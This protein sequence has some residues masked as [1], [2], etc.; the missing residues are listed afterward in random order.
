MYKRALEIAAREPK[1]KSNAAGLIVISVAA[2]VLLAG[3][4]SSV[5]RAV[6]IAA[7]LLVHELGHYA[8]MRAFGYTD[9]KIFLIPFFGAATSGRKVGAPAWQEAIVLLMGPMPGLLAGTALVLAGATGTARE[10]AGIAV[11]VNAANLL[12][13]EPLDG[14]RVMT[15]TVFARHPALETLTAFAGATALIYFGWQLRAWVLVGVGAFMLFLLLARA[16]VASAA[17]HL[18]RKWPD[19]PVWLAESPLDYQDDLSAQA[20]SIHRNIASRPESHALW[21]RQIHERVVR[22]PPTGGTTAA[23]L[24]AYVACI[25]LAALAIAVTR[26]G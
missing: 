16:K 26:Q 10:L 6:L 7:V 24:F 12:P 11:F 1:Q 19:V 14:G 5:M 25:G 3:Q 22:K 13:I 15:R 8:A 23:L 20:A 4:E 18:S 17:A 2:F 21:I 9:T